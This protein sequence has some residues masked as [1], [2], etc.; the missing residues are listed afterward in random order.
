MFFPLCS[1]FVE[2][3]VV[4]AWGVAWT[5]TT[6]PFEKLLL[7]L[8]ALPSFDKFG[9]PPSTNKQEQYFKGQKDNCMIVTL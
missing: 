3:L 5:V 1:G 7:Q 6:I 8:N 2:V 9:H 4:A